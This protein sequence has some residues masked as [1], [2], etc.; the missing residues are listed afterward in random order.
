MD[1]RERDISSVIEKLPEYTRLLFKLYKSPDIRR[2]HKLLLS[3]GIAYSVSP[4]ELIPGMIPVAGQ[5]DNLIIMLRCLRKVLK[6]S[7][8][9]TREKY[10]KEAG[11]TL[12]EIDEDINISVDTLKAIGRGTARVVSNT[13]RSAG[14]SVLYR[15]EKYKNKKI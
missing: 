12:E 10:L 6:A 2:R 13:V 14:Y 4:I 3:A 11:M 1:N 9:E 8:A 15:I 7:G 5:L